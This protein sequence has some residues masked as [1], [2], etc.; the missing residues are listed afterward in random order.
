M[1]ILN[2]KGK[3]IGELDDSDAADSVLVELKEHF[4]N[5]E[6]S[7]GFEDVA[8]VE[9]Y[10]EFSEYTLKPILMGEN[11]NKAEEIIFIGI[12]KFEI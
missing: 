8:Y 9:W 6:W 2:G 7:E 4:E 10:D 5:T 3:S 11:Y 12:G 1:L